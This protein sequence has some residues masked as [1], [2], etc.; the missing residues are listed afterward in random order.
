VSEEGCEDAASEHQRGKKRLTMLLDHA[1]VR[2]EDFVSER[3]TVQG[4]LT[5]RPATQCVESEGTDQRGF[6]HQE[7][8]FKNNEKC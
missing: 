5:N 4:D 8:L 6:L 3:D 2:L 1:A 7:V